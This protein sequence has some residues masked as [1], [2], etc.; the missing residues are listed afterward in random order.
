MNVQKSFKLKDFFIQGDALR[1][2]AKVLDCP[3]NSLE[4][5]C[6]ICFS[7]FGRRRENDPRATCYQE[8]WK[9][10]SKAAFG[11]QGGGSHDL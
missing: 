5:F 8:C 3:K 6:V 10:G 9:A 4:Y 2:E 1:N 7:E 11:R